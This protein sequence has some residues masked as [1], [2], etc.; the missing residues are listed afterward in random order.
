MGLQPM[1]SIIE[2]WQEGL[3]PRRGRRGWTA[4]P[5]TTRPRTSRGVVFL[6]A[7]LAR[8]RFG[9]RVERVQQGFP[10]CIAYRA[11]RRVRIEF[12]YRSSSFAVHRHEPSECDWIVC[13][14]HD[15]PAHPRRLR[16]VELRREF[17]LGF[18]VWVQPI[19]TAGG[20]DYGAVLRKT[21]A[22]GQWSLPRQASKGDLVLYYATAPSSS[23][24]D[25]FRIT[26]PVGHVKAGYRQGK[27][28]MASIRR[29]CTLK[30]PIHLRELREHPILGDAGFVRGGMRTRFRVSAH[31]PELYAMI[32]DRN[33]SVRRTLRAF[34]PD[35]LE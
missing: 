17:G 1:S 14:I 9:L 21:R 35:R 4:L 2:L 16:I 26:S 32:V 29:V 28:Y 3:W 6:F 33:P 19:G 25:L 5:S 10:D 24:A 34:G 18:N 22:D 30:S 15:W 23:I 27:D 11:G 13:W 7:H 8:R 31:W 12:E 20:V